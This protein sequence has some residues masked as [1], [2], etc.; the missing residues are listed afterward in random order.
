M[1]RKTRGEKT[2]RD[3]MKDKNKLKPIMAQQQTERPLDTISANFS[4]DI[5]DKVKQYNDKINELDEAYTSLIP[6]KQVLVRI[7]LKEVEIKNGVLYP[8]YNIMYGETANGVQQGIKVESP[9]P[10]S[11]KAIVIG[12]PEHNSLPVGSM[13]LLDKNAIKLQ[14]T[15]R[16]DDGTVEILNKF[17]H[18]DLANPNKVIVDPLDRNYGY[19]LVDNFDII[20]QLNNK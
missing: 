11:T 1:S 5:N 20:F 17:I 14:V 2:M 13:V 19:V 18:P 16:G 3:I 9:Y 8:D 6:R 4:E 15:G 10:F 12:I 7:V